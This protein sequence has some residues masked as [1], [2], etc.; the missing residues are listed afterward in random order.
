MNAHDQE[1]ESGSPTAYGKD[2]DAIKSRCQQMRARILVEALALSDEF[3][4]RRTQ[5][6]GGLFDP[7]NL[8]VRA[9]GNS[10]QIY[11]VLMHFREGRH[12][13]TTNVPKNRGATDYDLA[14]LKA[15]CADWLQEIAVDIEMRARPM[16]ESLKLLGEI[17]R[18]AD[19]VARRMSGGTKATPDTEAHA[20]TAH[21]SET[22]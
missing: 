13:G 1:N 7:L 22:T 10:I 18:A 16:R 12:K 11:W 4:Q 6:A 5:A 2:A 19:V 20:A 9:R 8:S 14:K 3:V 15:R 21:N 17:E